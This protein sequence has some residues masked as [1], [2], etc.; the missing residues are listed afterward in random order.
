MAVRKS[1]EE[2][3]VVGGSREF[4]LPKCKAAL[5]TGGFS[6]IQMSET[7]LQLEGALR[8]MTVCGSIV[9]TLLPDG[10]NTKIHIKSTGNMDNLFALLKSPNK[11]IAAAFKRGIK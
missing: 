6:K 1:S 4:W 2:T 11:A 7:L 5:E 3:L 8:K 10:G 9:V